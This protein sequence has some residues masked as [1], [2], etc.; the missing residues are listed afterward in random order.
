MKLT[1]K[2]KLN[3][4]EKGLLPN[5]LFKIC[6]R[7]LNLLHKTQGVRCKIN[8]EGNNLFIAFSL[9]KRYLRYNQ[10]EDLTNML[11]ELK[12]LIQNSKK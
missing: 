7:T 12:D 3:L 10:I 9:P 11:S 6:K 1:F 2:E 8:T 5:S 4:K